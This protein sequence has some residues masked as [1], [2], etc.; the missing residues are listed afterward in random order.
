MTRLAGDALRFAFCRCN[1]YIRQMF[2]QQHPT[3][4]GPFLESRGADP[5]NKSKDFGPFPDDSYSEGGRL[6][7]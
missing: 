7:M 5:Y 4:P 3:M 2:R 1:R 6:D